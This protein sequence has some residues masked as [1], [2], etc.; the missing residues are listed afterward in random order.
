MLEY[1]YEENNIKVLG[2]ICAK[3]HRVSDHE[4]QSGVPLRCQANHGRTDI[5]THSAADEIRQRGKD[6]TGSAP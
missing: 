5:N 4:L 1:P 6:L 2:T 3:A